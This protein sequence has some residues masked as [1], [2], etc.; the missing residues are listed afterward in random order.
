MLNE[1]NLEIAGQ[2]IIPAREGSDRHGAA[3]STAD[4]I[5][6]RA[7]AAE[8]PRA[9]VVQQPVNGGGSD[10]LSRGIGPSSDSRPCRVIESIKRRMSAFSRS[11]RSDHG[12]ARA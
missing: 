12:P 2:W 10:L 8:G 5:G 3:I 7:L 9:Q 11:G 6:A 1:I 4:S